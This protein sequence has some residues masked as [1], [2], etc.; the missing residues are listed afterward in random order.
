MKIKTDICNFNAPPYKAMN[1]NNNND[2]EAEEQ[3]R[4]MIGYDENYVPMPNSDD[5]NPDF[6]TKRGSNVNHPDHYNKGGV[7]CIDGIKAAC[8]GLTGEEAFCTGSALKYLWRWK[9]KNG[10]EDLEKAIW[11]INRMIQNL[12]KEE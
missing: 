10:K 11:Y 2:K 1:N 12:D 6:K 7:E 3:L 5:I 9:W 4:M 8:A